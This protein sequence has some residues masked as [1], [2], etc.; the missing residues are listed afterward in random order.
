LAAKAAGIKSVNG[1]MTA[2][3]DESRRRK[4]TQQPTNEGISKSGQWWAATVV[5]LRHDGNATATVMDGNGREW[6][7][8]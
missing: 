7:Q 6:R 4:T 3:D 1:C 5:M 2:C 8:Q